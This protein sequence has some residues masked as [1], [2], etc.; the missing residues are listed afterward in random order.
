MTAPS[1]NPGRIIAIDALRGL[2]VIGIVWMNVHAFA[3]PS[4]A[5]YNPVAWGGETT[6]DRVIWA[7]SFVFVE[8]KFRTLFAMMFGA[9]CLILLERAEERKLRAHSARMLVLFVLG[10][11]HS[12]LFAS[13]DVLRAYALSGLVLPF[14]AKLSPRELYA[15]T[16]GLVVLH[17]AAGLVAFGPGVV[18]FYAGRT[19][20]EAYLFAERRFG[21]D[22][23]AL[24]YF[25]ELGREG[26]DERVARRI[27]DWPSHMQA[28]VLS[29]PLNLSAMALGMGLWKHRFLA[30]EWRTFRLQRIA[31]VCAI[32][33]IPALLGLA[34]WVANNGFPGAVVGSANLIV[35]APFDMLLGLTYAALAMAFFQPGGVVTQKLATVG[36]LSLTNYLMT[37]FIFAAIFSGWGLGL[38]GEFNR[39]QSFVVSFVPIVAM[40]V[41]SPF[42]VR[43]FG[44][45]PFERVWRAAAKALS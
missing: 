19:T 8:D 26:F 5:Y 30:G 17:C 44:Q 23:A 32:V 4:P 9:G 20:G 37:S 25:L 43:R 15:V 35:S 39:A 3:L 34:L 29:I 10:V 31:A 22:P 28:V 45:G 1:P 11:V 16:V 36:R 7:A 38:F 42:W 40:L 2:S 21:G 41:W 18:D 12:V 6:L 33:A 14:L 27:V 24:N 13:N